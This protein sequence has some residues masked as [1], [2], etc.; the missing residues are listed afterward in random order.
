MRLAMLSRRGF[1]FSA[2]GPLVAGLYAQLFI[3]D[4]PPPDDV[5]HH[6][7]SELTLLT[8]EW[9]LNV[10]LPQAPD[11]AVAFLRLSTDCMGFA[12]GLAIH[13]NSPMGEIA[14]GSA[15]NKDPA[16]GVIGVQTGPLW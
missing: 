2:S 7:L 5:L 8:S 10:P 1:L 11:V 14:C 16:E 6:P 13:R 4:E 15:W 12:Q 9:A 3:L